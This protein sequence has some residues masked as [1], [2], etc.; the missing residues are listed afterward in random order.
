MSFISPEDIGDRTMGVRPAP[1]SPRLHCGLAHT[2]AS[3]NGA[4]LK[5]TPCCSGLGDATPAAAT[6][7]HRRPGATASRPV[8]CA[9]QLLLS[10]N[11]DRGPVTFSFDDRCWLVVV[12][13]LE[14]GKHVWHLGVDVRGALLVG[15]PRCR[16]SISGVCGGRC[17]D[18]CQGQL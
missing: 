13:M 15:A 17:V 9:I 3:Q 1:T 14:P 5:R 7:A 6:R 16:Q 2:I 12:H 10:A 11:V 8:S 4:F 18:R